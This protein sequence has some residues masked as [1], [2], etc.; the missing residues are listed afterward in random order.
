VRKERR[1]GEKGRGMGGVLQEKGERQRERKGRGATGAPKWE[2]RRCDLPQCQQRE[3]GREEEWGQ[4]RKGK[5]K[6]AAEG[7]ARHRRAH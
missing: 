5:G 2:R 3:Q 6:R 1:K 7:K 4:E